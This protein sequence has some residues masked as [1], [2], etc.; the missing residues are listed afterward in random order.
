MKKAARYNIGDEIIYRKGYD[1]CKSKIVPK[2]IDDKE[3]PDFLIGR[4][5]LE[6]GDYLTR[7]T[8]VYESM[9]EAKEAIRKSIEE[10]IKTCEACAKHYTDKAMALK[11]KITNYI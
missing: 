7:G 6:N 4:V 9:E 1:I 2:P 3:R 11:G 8:F 10:E 5:D